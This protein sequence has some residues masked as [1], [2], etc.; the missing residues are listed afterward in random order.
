MY[1]FKRGAPSLMLVA[2]LAL[3]CGSDVSEDPQRTTALQPSA[4]QNAAETGPNRPPTIEGL[5]LSPAEPDASD[6]LQA[7]VK[8]SDAD[9][10]RAR[11]EYTWWVN[12]RRAG[13]GSSFD[14]EETRRGARIE[15]SVIADDGQSQSEPATAAVTIGNTPP[16]IEAIR[17]EPSGEWHTGQDVAALPDAVDP[18]GD[19]LTFAYTWFHNGRPVPEDGPTFD[20]SSLTRGDKVNLV[21]VA[22]DGHSESD[23][24]RTEEMEVSNSA[25]EIT[26]SPGAIGPDGFFR[27]QLKVKD[28]DGDRSFMY[29]LVDGPPGMNVDVLGGDVVWQPVSSNAGA[30]PVE[31]EVDDRMGGKT[32]QSFTL[33]VIFQ[34]DPTPPASADR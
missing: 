34:D 16:V 10:D 7:R 28:P 29:R 2:A 3:G 20:G 8:V 12:G 30:H 15:V 6:T 9:G 1:G 31:I 4:S 22:S 33:N 18:D 27:Y 11:I 24:L 14:L 25:P 23:E 13:E 26:S 21:V 19:P 17:F 5:T 32:T